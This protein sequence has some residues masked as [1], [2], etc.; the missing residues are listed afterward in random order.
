MRCSY[1]M[2]ISL[3]ATNLEFLSHLVFATT[4]IVSIQASSCMSLQLFAVPLPVC[5]IP[6]P[7]SSAARAI[8][9]C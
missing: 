3:E 2:I 4:A 8:G 7:S 1:H 9:I 6:Q 5:A